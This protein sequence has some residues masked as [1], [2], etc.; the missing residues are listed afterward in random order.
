[1][2]RY[3][4]SAPGATDV[5]GKGLKVHYSNRPL[6]GLS[7]RR[8]VA[9]TILLALVLSSFGFAYTHRGTAASDDDA[10]WN[11]WER[12]DRPVAEL[13]VDRTW[14]WGPAN[15]TTS[16]M[17]AYA[18]SPD[19]QRLVRYFDKSRMEINDLTADPTNLWYVTNGLLARDL[20]LGQVQIGEEQFL[21]Y[22]VPEINIAG[23]LDDPEGPTYRTFH[24]VL[25]DVV[26]HES[27]PIG[28]TIVQT[29][30]R[31]GN[32][33]VDESLAVYGIT[34]AHYEPR[35]ERTV[36]S[37]FWEFLHSQGL[38]YQDSQLTED[39]LFENAYYST[40]YP[41]T[42]SFWT[43]VRVNGVPKRVLVQVFERRVLTY[44]P[45]NP[46]GWQVE[47]GNVGLHYYHWF[48]E[49]LAGEDSDSTPE[50]GVTPSPTTPPSIDVPTPVPTPT[51]WPVIT[52]TPT[53][54]SP[55]PSNPGPSPSDG[56]AAACLDSIEQ[57][58]LTLINNYRQQNGLQPLAN[59][60]ALNVA[61]Y[62]HSKDMGER[63]YFSHNTPEGLTSWD[64]MA[65][66]GYTY[67]THM[68]EN[69]AAGQQTAQQVFD[70]WRNSSRHNQ[71]ML[72]PNLRVIGI[73]RVEVPG[74]PY[75]VYWTTKFGGY[76]DAVPNC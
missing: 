44:T 12:T 16:H 4:T 13:Q 5:Q 75:E 28:S 59:S 14:T 68:A 50:P 19:G 17:E 61:S 6:T 74:S 53:P 18:E 21:F 8:F 64:R 42:D 41:V 47:S 43:M 36:A 34:T 76:V 54:A 27:L 37:V 32:V 45:D 56:T 10:F 9:L 48:Y 57:Q 38:V 70:G 67:N 23:D 20:I 35:T 3:S 69:I 72:G 65:A 15:R 51:P 25:T 63:R 49:I 2:N 22:D 40:G 46:N 11:V 52:P 29:I 58:F 1:V 71:N 7:F 30:D 26:R 24:S 60:R 31:D 66:E 73:G 62:K 55:S 39:R 33:G